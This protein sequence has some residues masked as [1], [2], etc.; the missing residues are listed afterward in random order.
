[1]KNDALLMLRGAFTPSGP[2]QSRS[3]FAGRL[4]QSLEIAG[5]VAQPGRH[6]V[7]Y[8]ERGVGKTSL[9]NVLPE[10]LSV[11]NAGYAPTSIRIN[12]DDGMTF[13]ALWERVASELGVDGAEFW[14]K[15]RP[16]PDDIRMLLRNIKP[17]TLIV[18][19]E[20]DR[21]ADDETLSLMADTL[22]TLSDNL[23][24]T[25]LVIVGVADTLESLVGE[26]ESVSRAIEEV[27]LPRM[28]AD[29]IEEVVTTG[30]EL[31]DMTATGDALAKVARLTEGL[32]SYAHALPLHAA[33]YAIHDDRK[34]VTLSDVDVA[35]NKI[36]ETH[37]A[38]ASYL[39]AIASPQKKNNFAAVLAACAITKK[40]ELGYFYAGDV[41]EPLSQILG[42]TTPISSYARTLTVFQTP[43][44]GGALSSVGKAHGV[45]YRFRDPMLQPFA[46]MAAI[47][48]N[49]INESLANT[50]LAT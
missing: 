19:D 30:L 16:R 7:V 40:D 13:D 6:V 20:Y 2:V 24:P 38:R 50:L 11:I 9:T 39:K 1:M 29:E 45:R 5:A 3:R 33:S 43:E 28:A 22:K 8:G 34:E 21:M 41:S 35:V 36:V 27:L 23:V 14:K 44:R 37:S 4:E 26:H 32:P 17:P 46:L 18:I 47:R 42:K 25:K 49:V 12:C 15:G 31:V 10:M 48:N